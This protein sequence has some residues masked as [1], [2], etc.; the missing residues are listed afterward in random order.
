M[1]KRAPSKTSKRHRAPV[2][3][4][5]LRRQVRI[6]LK[7]GPAPLH[8]WLEEQKGVHYLLNMGLTDA[9]NAAPAVDNS[10][11]G[12]ELQTS[13]SEEYQK[14][15]A[16]E[17]KVLGNTAYVARKFDES[18]MYYQSAWE[19]HKDITYLTNLSAAYYEKGD[20]ARSASRRLR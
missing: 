10:F 19:L 11:I 6:L 15:M 16:D 1:N 17:E 2:G 8:V 9:S 13:M 4:F 5:D 3:S 7:F 12:T 18:I 14:A 20:H